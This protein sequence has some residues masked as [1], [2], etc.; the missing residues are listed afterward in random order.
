MT[1]TSSFAWTC[2]LFTSYPGQLERWGVVV[3]RMSGN[4]SFRVDKSRCCNGNLLNMFSPLQSRLYLMILRFIQVYCSALL[5]SRLV[6]LEPTVTK[7]ENRNCESSQQRK[8]CKDEPAHFSFF[9][10][11][12]PS[13]G[14]TINVVRRQSRHNGLF[15]VCPIISPIVTC[16]CA[17]NVSKHP[18][19]KRQ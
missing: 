12:V 6:Y 10:P 13:L 4:C 11:F 7:V 2:L 17:A 19:K 14:E 8:L 16:C 9:F 18:K 15:K 3:V 1:K 5:R